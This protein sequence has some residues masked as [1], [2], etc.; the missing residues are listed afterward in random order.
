MT[1][2]FT[3]ML[4]NQNSLVHL[5]GASRSD[6]LQVFNKRR[7]TKW[8][9]RLKPSKKYL[10]IKDFRNSRRSRWGP[11]YEKTFTPMT[12]SRIP[13]NI[14]VDTF[15]ILIR[16]NRLEDVNRRLQCGDWEDVDPDLRSSSPEPIYDPKSGHRLNTREVRNRENYL[17]EKNSLIEEL[18]LIDKSYRPPSDYRPPKKTRK[19]Y[20]NEYDN[21]KHKLVALILGPHGVTQ[22]ELEKKSGCRI[23]VRGKGSNW[24]NNSMDRT[25]HDE[26]EA[27]HVYLVADTEDQIR[28]GLT[29]IE[30]I[31]D[32]ISEEHYKHKQMQKNAIAVMYGYQTDTACENCGDR[33]RTWACPLNFGNF[34]KADVKC[35]ICGDKSHPTVDCPERKNLEEKNES[36]SDLVKFIK[37]ID[38]LKKNAETLVLEAEKKADDIRNSIIFTGKIPEPINKDLS[39]SHESFVD[40]NKLDNRQTD[41]SLTLENINKHIE[42]EELTSI[43]NPW[44]S[45][46]NYIT[47]DIN[48]LRPMIPTDYRVPINPIVDNPNVIRAPAVNYVNP[49]MNNAMLA[50]MNSYYMNPF[51]TPMGFP[52]QMPN[53][54]MNYLPSSFQGKIHFNHGL[55]ASLM[56]MHGNYPRPPVIGMNMNMSIPNVNYRMNINQ[57]MMRPP[58][59][60]QPNFFR[61][62]NEAMAQPPE[63]Q[64]PENERKDDIEVD[65][66]Q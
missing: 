16:R 47:H 23:S 22:K 29:M 55:N 32:P 12:I 25:Y 42:I 1:D 57:N 18:I 14:D 45:I 37:E 66:I 40:L 39:N 36:E 60:N 11:E 9:D 17:K 15:E 2:F 49:Q 26:N 65:K 31:L 5:G 19:I 62:P 61:M 10:N 41:F 44:P 58:T 34:T 27:L 59:I 38:E 50:G 21:E 24:T 33:H 48:K 20:I 7:N 13:D 53:Q 6:Y 28:K 3:S 56:S 63:P 54:G 51:M 35:A 64:E 46:N 52:G 30:P 43:P 4:L 8:D